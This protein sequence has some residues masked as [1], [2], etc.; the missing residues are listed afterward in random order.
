MNRYLKYITWLI[1]GTVLFIISGCS[2]DN[3]AVQFNLKNQD[4]Q[5]VNVVGEKAAVIFLFT[6]YT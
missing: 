4:N 6:T 3:Q 5:E 2:S 1:V